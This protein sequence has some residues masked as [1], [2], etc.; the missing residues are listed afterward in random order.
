MS[1]EITTARVQ[2]YTTLVQ[3][4]L[5]QGES[6]LRGAV[7]IGSHRGKQAVAVDQ[8]GVV[9]A[10]QVAA[11]HADTQIIETPHARRWVFPKHY[12]IGDYIDDEDKVEL[13]WDPQGPYAQAQA[14]A[15]GRAIDNE[16]LRS[17]FETSVTGETGSGTEA[18]DTT[19]YSI[20]S[21]SVGM[22]LTK[23]KT[24]RRMLMA[25]DVNL[26]MEP[27][28]CAVTARQAD[29]LLNETQMISL[30]YNSRPVL[31]DGKISSFMGFNFI[32]TELID[33]VS[34]ERACPIWV[35]SG[36]HLGTWRE[37]FGMIDRVPQKRNNILVQ[38]Q[39][40]IGACRVE[41]GKVV[42]VLCAES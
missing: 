1:N 37:P 27:A 15:M 16:I 10:V 34:S 25:A 29:D 36:V 28:Y 39:M 33:T 18:F 40:S 32:H 42:R 31:V 8:V 26:D 7:M 38:T 17:F 2:E 5:Q 12:E 11:R 41:Q 4:L 3:H 20:A 30:D 9:E 14:R 23:L 35:R 6:R 19:N 13:I 24:A 22:T 21:G